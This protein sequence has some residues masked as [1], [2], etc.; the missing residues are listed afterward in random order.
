VDLLA[1]LGGKW[2]GWRV[3]LVVAYRPSDLLLS[4]HPFGPVKLE[5]QGRGV[6]REIALPFLSRADLDRYLALA[7]PGHQFPEEFAA[8]IHARTEGNPLFLIDLLRYLEDRGSLIQ[9][10]GHWV[11]AQAVP[12]IRGEL[13]ESVR[14]LIQRKLEQLSD[15]DRR[16]LMAASVQGHEFDS[17]VVA[18]VL[19]LGAAEVEER[20]GVLERVHAL[21]RVVREQEF[22]DRTL[23]LRCAFVHVLYQNALYSSLAPTRK[24]GWSAAAAQALLDHYGAKSAAVATELALLLEAARDPGRAAHHFL[25]AA[26]NAARSYANQEAMVLAR[27]G[28]GLLLTLPDTPE[29]ARQELGLQMVL[30]AAAQATRGYTSSEAGAACSRARALCEQ[31][32]DGVPRFPVLW[33][34]ALFYLMRAELPTAQA[35]GEQ[36]LRLGQGAQDPDL[37]M[38]A[39]LQLGAILCYLPDNPLAL[40]HCKRANTLYDAERHAS[41]TYLYGHNPL[42]LSRCFGAWA[43]WMLGYPDQG[44][45]TVN[46]AVAVARELGHPMSL[47][48]ALFFAAF[49]HWLRRERSRTQELC[50]TLITLATEQGMAD[51]RAAAF[52]WHGWALADGPDRAEGLAQLRQ[53]SAAMQTS[54]VQL[55]R[56]VF[57]GMMAAL[58]AQ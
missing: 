54:G 53:G 40:E 32:G 35:L 26:E 29:R 48:S 4:R 19:G 39:H 55:Y 33:R 41:H 11:L 21:V 43:L 27:R 49:L 2:A 52:L 57:Q 5:L 58:L 7:F 15:S 17:V 18:R 34:L 37:C 14:G 45:D 16:L 10:Q 51:Y 1:Y 50:E 8:V 9:D 47:A 12:D 25:Q 46:A 36:C 23:T 31:L 56:T 24:A 42:V 28:L 30:S 6:C 44:R 3:L 22:P 20:L 38:E 13:P